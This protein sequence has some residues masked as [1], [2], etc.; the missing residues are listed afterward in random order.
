MGR[1]GSDSS[2]GIKSFTKIHSVCSWRPQLDELHRNRLRVRSALFTLCS[3]GQG[4]RWR[5]AIRALQVVSEGQL[6]SKTQLDLALHTT[7]ERAPGVQPPNGNRGSCLKTVSAPLDRNCN[8]APSRRIAWEPGLWTR[9]ATVGGEP[10]AFIPAKSRVTR[11]A[12]G[13]SN[14][15]CSPGLRRNHPTMRATIPAPPT[16]DAQ[17][18]IGVPRSIEPKVQGA[19]LERVRRV[20]PARVQGFAAVPGAGAGAGAGALGA[21]GV[22]L[23]VAGVDGAVRGVLLEALLLESRTLCWAREFLV[24][25][26]LSFFGVF[27]CLWACSGFV[28]EWPFPA[29][30]P[31]AP[32]PERPFPA[33]VPSVC[34]CGALPGKEFVESAA[35][36]AVLVARARRR[37]FMFKRARERLTDAKQ[38]A[39]LPLGRGR[40]V[41]GHW[42]FVGPTTTVQPPPT[43]D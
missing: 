37:A 30:V 43:N 16:L 20:R 31:S 12:G 6:V 17:E 8:S 42:S 4:R 24:F 25:F 11:N 9:N 33:P 38:L 7:W 13:R 29:P 2:A 3:Q 15:S 5:Y 27:N 32:L 22:A 41:I 26:V 14:R 23:G 28:A 1:A 18:T 21:E 19:P 40:V 36:R 35:N 39:I 10:L 34:V